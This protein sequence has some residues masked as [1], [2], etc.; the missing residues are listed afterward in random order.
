MTQRHII[1]FN[2]P[3]K[4]DSKHVMC[5]LGEISNVQEE[6]LHVCLMINSLRIVMIEYL[7]ATGVAGGCGRVTWPGLL[8]RD[9]LG[10]PCCRGAA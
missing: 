2:L 10:V 1:R 4:F 8:P 3:V 5:H 7:G 9:P 6:C